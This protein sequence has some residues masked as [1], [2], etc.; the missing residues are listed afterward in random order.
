M[1]DTESGIVMVARQV[2]LQ[3]A[4]FPMRKIVSAIFTLARLL[5]L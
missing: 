1:S 3:N 4:Y 5:Q 2:Q